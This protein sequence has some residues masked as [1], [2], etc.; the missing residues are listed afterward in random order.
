MSASTFR[1]VALS[2]VVTVSVLVSSA[3]VW[4]VSDAAFTR[5]TANTWSAGAVRFGPNQ[6][7]TAL[8]S[9]TGMIPGS[10]GTTCVQ[11]T[12]TGTVNAPARLYLRT[13]GL[14][15]SGLGAYLTFQVREGAGTASDC[16]DFVIAGIALYNTFGMRGSGLGYTLSGFSGAAHDWGSGVGDWTAAP[17]S[18]RTYRFDWQLQDFN[19]AQNLTAAVFTWEAQA[20]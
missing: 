12:Y 18:T 6:P 19:A 4:Q 1:R 11:L 10:F 7:A 20:A 2:A 9:V 16:S 14:T 17:G 8:F 13:T 15:G 3:V 5:T